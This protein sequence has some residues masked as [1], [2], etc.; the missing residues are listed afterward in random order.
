MF[1]ALLCHFKSLNLHYF[2]K[3]FIGFFVRGTYQ[4]KIAKITKIYK[5]KLNLEQYLRKIQVVL[6]KNILR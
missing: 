6:E 4:L 5:T 3:A 1:A 2:K